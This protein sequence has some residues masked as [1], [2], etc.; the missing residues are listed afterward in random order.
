MKVNRNMSNVNPNFSCKVIVFNIKKSLYGLID[1]KRPP[2]EATRKYWHI[3]NKKY[4]DFNIYQFAVGLVDGIAVTAFKIN[5]WFLTQDKTPERIGR[6]EFEG[7]ETKETEELKDFNW[8]KQR[9]LC[10]GHWGFGG[11]LVIEFDGNEK[12]RIIKGSSD[13]LWHHC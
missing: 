11:Y 10:M 12:F 1:H 4:L 13:K 5:N 8:S 9:D 6:Y 2:Y 3:N 7:I